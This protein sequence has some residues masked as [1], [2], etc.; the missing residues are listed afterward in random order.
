M[1]IRFLNVIDHSGFRQSG[2]V[3]YFDDFTFCS[4]DFVGNIRNRGDHVHIEFTIEA[5]LNNLHVEE[6]KKA[7]AKSKSESS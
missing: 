4:V 1:N 6:T 7:A 5:F 3:V 2:R